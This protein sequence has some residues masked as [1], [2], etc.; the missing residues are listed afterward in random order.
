MC[1]GGGFPLSSNKPFST[2]NSHNALC[3]CIHNNS[4]LLKYCNIALYSDNKRYVLV[5]KKFNFQLVNAFRTRQQRGN[6]CT[7]LC[8][9]CTNNNNKKHV[10]RFWHQGHGHWNN[11]EKSRYSIRREIGEE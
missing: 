5:K 3:F 1:G 2:T 9:Q 8:V 4:I 10:S 11:L 6:H 7:L